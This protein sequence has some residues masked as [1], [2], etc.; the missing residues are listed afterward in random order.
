MF[1]F[2]LKN[3]TQKNKIKPLFWKRSKD[4]V[5]SLSPTV[6]NDACLTKHMTMFELY[7]IYFWLLWFIHKKV[8]HRIASCDRSCKV[9]FTWLGG[10]STAINSGNTSLK[11]TWKSHRDAMMLLKLLYMQNSLHQR[12]TWASLCSPWHLLSLE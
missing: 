11:V 10:I 2:K 5:L 12:Y 8:V 9:M 6:T 3:D 4:A 7:G 1:V